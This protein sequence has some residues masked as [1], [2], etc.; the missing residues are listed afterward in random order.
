MYF[1]ENHDFRLIDTGYYWQVE[2]RNGHEYEVEEVDEKYHTSW[3]VTQKSEIEEVIRQEALPIDEIGR[4][5]MTVFWSDYQSYAIDVQTG[6]YK[7]ALQ[8]LS[9]MEK[10]LN[11]PLPQ[12]FYAPNIQN[13]QPPGV[14][15]PPRWRKPR[16]KKS[17]A[18]S[19]GVRRFKLGSL[20]VNG[21]QSISLVI[22]LKEFGCKFH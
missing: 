16:R 6:G 7:Q 3:R 5:F 9:D 11:E 10:Q 20:V 8:D 2:K 21:S 17:R 12:E 19:S 4:R 13:I 18:V 1:D 15:R 14:K 22:E